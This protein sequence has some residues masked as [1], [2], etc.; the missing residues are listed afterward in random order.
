M[1]HCEHSEETGAPIV[2]CWCG[3]FCGIVCGNWYPLKFTPEQL[4]SL[5]SLSQ[6]SLIRGLIRSLVS[7]V[8]FLGCDL[9]SSFSQSDLEFKKRKKNK[10]NQDPDRTGC[11][12]QRER[13]EGKIFLFNSYTKFTNRKTFQGTN[14]FHRVVLDP[15]FVFFFSGQQ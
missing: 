3:L 7:G 9:V 13:I 4:I 1:Q 12:C 10:Q 2:A 8:R 5:K 11:D 15:L 14:Y 6:H